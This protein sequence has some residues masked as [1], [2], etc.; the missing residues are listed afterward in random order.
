MD[1]GLFWAMNETGKSIGAAISN[2]NLIAEYFMYFYTFIMV[3][4]AIFGIYGF[5]MSEIEKSKRRKAGIKE[6]WEV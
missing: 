6:W 1:L 2:G 3:C 5:V 4:L